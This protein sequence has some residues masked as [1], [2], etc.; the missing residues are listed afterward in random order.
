M[1]TAWPLPTTPV[2]ALTLTY[3]DVETTGLVPGN[4]DRVCEIALLRMHGT[5]EETRFES[6]VHPQR[7]MP[8]EVTA[9][10]GITEAMLAKAPLF[11][12]LLP[13]VRTL[14]QNAV[15]VGHNTRFDLRFLRYE[16]RA[17]G[18]VL[19]EFPMIDTLALAQTYYRFPHNSLQAIATALGVP[20]APKHRAMADVLA[21]RGVLQRF[22]AD[23]QQQGPVTLAHLMYPRSQHTGAEIVTMLMTLQEALPGGVL[24]HLRYHGWKAPETVRIVQ[25]LEVY[26]AGG[27][28][29]LRAFCHLRREER[30][31][32]FD[33]IAELR[34][35]TEE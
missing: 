31:F 3:L 26:Y 10:H 25:P 9:V 23:L 15:I 1:T 34:I 35:L 29:F 2:E 21:T 33:R 28:G 6:L 14:L 5:Q 27:Y 4:G 18:H 13:T 30:S 12:E 8:P 17:A 22:I 32:R 19:P 11:V 24:L 7:S 16:W 20:H